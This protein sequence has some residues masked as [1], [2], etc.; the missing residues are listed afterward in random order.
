MLCTHAIVKT[1]LYL[2]GVLYSKHRMTTKPTSEVDRKAARAAR[3]NIPTSAD[4][5]AKKEARAKRYD[6]F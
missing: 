4:E 5:V 6:I 2:N 1:Y 3:F